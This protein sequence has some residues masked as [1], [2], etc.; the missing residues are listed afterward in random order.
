M[1]TLLLGML[2]VAVGAL[3]FGHALFARRPA[4]QIATGTTPGHLAGFDGRG[5]SPYG[6]SEPAD[7]RPA[8]WVRVRAASLLML[9]V[10]GIAALVGAVLAIAVVGLV[11]LAT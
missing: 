6:T 1:G 4:T 2:V 10:L 11:L 9:M 7:V 3:A 8:G 5:D